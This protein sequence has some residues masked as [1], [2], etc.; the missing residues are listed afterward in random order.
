MPSLE[1]KLPTH[2]SEGARRR[3]GSNRRKDRGQ[4]AGNEVSEEEARERGELEAVRRGDEDRRRCEQA[5][6]RER[7]ESY[8]PNCGITPE[9]E[10]SSKSSEYCEISEAISEAARSAVEGETAASDIQEHNNATTDT[11]TRHRQYLLS[12]QHEQ[13]TTNNQHPTTRS[14]KTNN[15]QPQPQHHRTTINT[16]NKTQ[17]GGRA[18]RSLRRHRPR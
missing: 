12:H 13:R 16:N 7:T 10:S 8:A 14:I 15:H 17:C 6:R 9:P 5:R 1:K 4:R 2:W 3:G 18:R 11:T